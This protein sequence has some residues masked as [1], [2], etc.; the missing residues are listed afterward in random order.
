MVQWLQRPSS[1]YLL[2]PR[3]GHGKG[4]REGNRGSEGVSVDG[5]ADVGYGERVGTSS[6]GTTAGII[7]E[8]LDHARDH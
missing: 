6:K 3:Q 5:V 4:I 8:G 7:L 2:H 1:L